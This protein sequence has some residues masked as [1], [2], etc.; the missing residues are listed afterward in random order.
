MMPE[1][2]SVSC[3]CNVIACYHPTCRDET[4]LY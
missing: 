1:Q 2:C 4:C 3:N